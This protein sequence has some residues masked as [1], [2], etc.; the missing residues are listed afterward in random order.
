MS[1]STQP[2]ARVC[3]D[4]SSLALSEMVLDQPFENSEVAD[5]LENSRQPLAGRGLF[6]FALSS[7]WRD[8]AARRQRPFQPSHMPMIW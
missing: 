3:H 1:D 2:P 8:Y 6:N 5:N 4:F 7:L